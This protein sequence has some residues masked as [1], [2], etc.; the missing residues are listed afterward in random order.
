M[1]RKVRQV[2]F[3]IS[4]W[5]KEPKSLGI[6]PLCRPFRPL[7]AYRTAINISSNSGQMGFKLLWAI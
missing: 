4:R 7:W 5:E 6:R 3:E 1:F 2:K